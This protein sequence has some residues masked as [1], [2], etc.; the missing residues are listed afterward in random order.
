MAMNS[1]K[2][3]LFLEMGNPLQLEIEGFQSRFKTS[4]V[5]IVH[6]SYLVIECPGLTM[7]VGEPKQF[8]VGSEIVVRCLSQGRAWG[9]KS[10]LLRVIS[11]PVTLLIIEFPEQVE[12]SSLR[13]DKRISCMLPGKIKIGKEQRKGLLLD[14]S[15]NGC[16]FSV[17]AAK[18]KKEA[19][20]GIDE[21]VT[22]LCQLPGMEGEQTLKGRV[23]HT[24][25]DEVKTSF[26]IEF[27]EIDSK[28]LKRI[29]Q[30]AATVTEETS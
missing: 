19:D 30:Y 28:I 26:G 13:S 18:D 29:A 3:P 14:I 8:T 20:V 10:R 22:I 27:D 1:L 2:H 25:R 9:F 23:R 15:E 21:E 12:N 5:G 24:H 17:K 4:L 16:F 7:L 6:D 11:T